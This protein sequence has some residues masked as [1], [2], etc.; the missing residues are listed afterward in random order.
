MDCKCSILVN[1]ILVSFAVFD[2]FAK[3]QV[4]GN[5]TRTANNSFGYFGLQAFGKGII[6]LTCNDRQHV[7][8]MDVVTEGVGIHTHS[9]PVDT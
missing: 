9:V 2:N 8:I 5:R 3:E 1:G 6:A 4:N 7:Y